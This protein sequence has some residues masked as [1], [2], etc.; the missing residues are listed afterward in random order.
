MRGQDQGGVGAQVPHAPGEGDG[1]PRGL[2][3]GS[4]QQRPRAAEAP[5]GAH[6]RK[7]LLLLQG[8]GFAVAA[9][10]EATPEVGRGVRLEVGLEGRK[11]HAAVLP[12][13]GDERREDPGELQAAGVFR[14]RAALTRSRSFTSCGVNASRKSLQTSRMAQSPASVRTGATIALPEESPTADHAGTEERS[15]TTV[16]PWPCAA[17]ASGPPPDQTRSGPCGRSSEVC[18]ARSSP[19]AT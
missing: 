15:D 9:E 1:R 6:E 2:E 7:L 16:G 13:W 4:D 10:D 8:G 14:P 11:V 18:T 5:R 17:S 3:P 19:S 12:E